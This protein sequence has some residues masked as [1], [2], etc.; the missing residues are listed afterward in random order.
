MMLKIKEVFR[1]KYR[2]GVG[3]LPPIVIMLKATSK[4]IMNSISRFTILKSAYFQLN[5]V[6]LQMTCAFLLQKDK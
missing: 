1:K 5:V 6:S 3:K 2:L 4:P